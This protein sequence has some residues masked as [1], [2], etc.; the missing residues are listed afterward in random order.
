M[1]L[2]VINFVSNEKSKNDGKKDMETSGTML[3]SLDSKFPKVI[4]IHFM[5]FFDTSLKKRESII[6]IG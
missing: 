4:E 1:Q 6:S 3:K 2:G 5:L